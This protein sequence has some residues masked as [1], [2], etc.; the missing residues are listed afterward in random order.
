MSRA[1]TPTLLPHRPPFLFVD[2][3]LRLEDQRIVTRWTAKPDAD[4]FR[5]H[6]PGNPIVPAVLL[7]ECC[8]QSGALLLMNLSNNP[9][10]VVDR[11]IEPT[12]SPPLP[13]V[14]RIG[15]ARFKRM[16]TPGQAVE[17]EVTLDDTLDQAYFLT[18]R[19]T[20][21]GRLAARVTFA[22]TLAHPTGEDP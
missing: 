7:C 3:I 1:L 19:A 6:Y 15:D 14:T 2:E 5:G 9:S 13:L 12:F 4:F 20:V 17:V 10:S 18:G 21:N 11:V 16:V 8:F 22:C